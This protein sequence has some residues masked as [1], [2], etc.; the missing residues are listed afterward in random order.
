[1]YDL[2]RWVTYKR[3]EKDPEYRGIIEIYQ[4]KKLVET[5]KTKTGIAH[6]FVLSVDFDGDDVWVGTS[7]GLSHGILNPTTLGLSK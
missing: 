7:H 6:N 5:R 4:G 3:N 2:N 1:D